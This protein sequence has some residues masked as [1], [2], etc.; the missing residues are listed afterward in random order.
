MAHLGSLQP[1]NVRTNELSALSDCA[2]FCALRLCGCCQTR[3]EL[4]CPFMPQHACPSLP[5]IRRCQ[6]CLCSFTERP[7][8]EPHA[9][10]LV[11]RLPPSLADTDSVSQSASSTSDL[12][13][14]YLLLPSPSPRVL[15]KS[16]PLG[17]LGDGLHP[18]S[19]P[20][21]AFPLCL[22]LPDP[23]FPPASL[24]AFT[25]II[26]LWTHR[27]PSSPC[28]YLLSPSSVI[29]CLPRRL[30]PPSLSSATSSSASVSR[31]QLPPPASSTIYRLA[32]LQTP[33]QSP[34]ST[35]C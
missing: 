7:A 22:Y 25:P 5:P 15:L 2:R 12:S 4:V 32:R 9:H 21:L 30:P 20:S 14:P 17:S 8:I 35:S 18:P 34:I 28:L 23:S 24:Q 33:I 26:S 3:S 13:P 19:F 16:S 6:A 1:R 11:V 31:I 29:V 27:S 10:T